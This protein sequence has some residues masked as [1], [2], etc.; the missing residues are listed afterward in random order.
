VLKPRGTLV[1]I[2]ASS[3]QGRAARVR[4]AFFIVEA[5]RPQ[6]AEVAR[7]IDAGA[8]RLIVGAVFS[9]ANGRD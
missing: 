6:L 8:L 9:L 7:L 2:R 1:T 5:N 4:E 3:E